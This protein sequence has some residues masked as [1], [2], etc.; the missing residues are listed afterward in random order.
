MPDGVPVEC[1]RDCGV[2]VAGAESGVERNAAADKVAR[3]GGDV[4]EDEDVV[5]GD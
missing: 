3:T 4:V 2:S 1:V 5:D